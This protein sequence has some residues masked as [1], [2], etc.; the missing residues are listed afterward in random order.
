LHAPFVTVPHFD[1]LFRHGTPS[2]EIAI[3]KQCADT[4][5]HR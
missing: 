1:L 2:V 5:S 4:C 3:A